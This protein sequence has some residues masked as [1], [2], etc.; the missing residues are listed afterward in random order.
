[1]DFLT[2][3]PIGMISHDELLNILIG[4]DETGGCDRRTLQIVAQMIG[5][6]E[7]FDRGINRLNGAGVTVDACR[8]GEGV[9]T[10]AVLL[11]GKQ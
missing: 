9:S 2:D 7:R 3:A 4:L 6:R 1:M 8:S 11:L 10:R 5:A